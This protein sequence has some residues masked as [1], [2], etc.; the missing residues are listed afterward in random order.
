MLELYY[1]FFTTFCD[2]N[3]FEELEMDTDSL[4]LALAGKELENCIRP[5]MRAK[6]QKLRSNDCVD[7]FIADPV[8]NFFPRT[9]CV[10]ELKE[11]F[12]STEMSGLSSKTYC[13]YDVTSNK[14][15]LSSKVPNKRVVEQSGDGPLQRDRGAL[16][17][18]LNVTSNK[19]GLRSNNHSAATYE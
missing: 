19:G 4:Y 16:N 1:N 8:A 7:G 11:E 14:L 10:R 13:C 18:E 15:K 6:W 17:E 12:R 3:K 5:E 2:V 9:C